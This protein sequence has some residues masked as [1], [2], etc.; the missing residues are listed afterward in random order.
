VRPWPARERSRGADPQDAVRVQA[1]DRL[2]EDQDARVTEER[3]GDPEAL[4]HA[5]REPA[6]PLGGHAGQP[7]SGPRIMRSVVDLSAP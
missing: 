5:K 2:V 1:V 3:R 7:V 6:G 4:A